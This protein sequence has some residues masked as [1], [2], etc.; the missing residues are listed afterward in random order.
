MFIDV[1]F[2]LN[3]GLLLPGRILD[4]LHL[5][6]RLLLPLVLIHLLWVPRR[7]VPELGR[8]VKLQGVPSGEYHLHAERKV[9]TL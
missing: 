3:K 6:C 7:P 1:S 8:A 5:P 2:P 9:T 4:L